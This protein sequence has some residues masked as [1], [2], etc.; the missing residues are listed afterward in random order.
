MR[1]QP[2][3]IWDAATWAEIDEA[4][5]EEVR[6]VGVVRRA[7]RTELVMAADG[8][9]PSWISGAEVKSAGAT[10]TKPMYIPEGDARAFAELSVG[11]RLTGAQVENESSLHTGK[12][13]ARMAAKQLAREEDKLVLMGPGDTD[14]VAT[15]R[16]KTGGEQS[17]VKTNV[18]P[19]PTNGETTLAAHLL[20]KLMDVIASL[21]RDGWPEP[22]SIILGPNLYVGASSQ[23]VT[24]ST[25]T[26]EG[27]LR[28]RAKHILVSDA[29]Q[30]DSGVVASLAGDPTTLYVAREPA[31]AFVSETFDDDDGVYY[32]F[33]VFERVQW[34]LR[35]PMSIGHLGPSTDTASTDTAS[36][37]TAST[38]TASTVTD[39]TG[40]EQVEQA[41]GS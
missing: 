10:A 19:A 34:A 28:S 16:Q 22:Y 31:T 17:Q 5:A 1:Y 23:I 29:L 27:R 40:S 24:G 15:Y 14:G 6:R 37:D 36:T 25:E 13:L 33:R 32:N 38:D 20:K 7:F 35:D 41:E 39:P 9:A 3:A 11:F 30:E 12:T 4:V 2:D 26:P 21:T 8:T 18:D